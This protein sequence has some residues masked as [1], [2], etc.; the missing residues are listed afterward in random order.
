MRKL[1]FAFRNFAKVA[2]NVNSKLMLFK[3]K[4]LS[5][6]EQYVA[7]GPYKPN[8]DSEVMAEPATLDGGR[9]N[10]RTCRV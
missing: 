4:T 10:L 8:L 7:G 5:Y 1:I 3:T 9:M 2:K 6:V